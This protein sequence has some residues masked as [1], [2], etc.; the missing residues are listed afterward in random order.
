MIM[1]YS[2]V[3]ICGWHVERARSD[4]LYDAS[5]IQRLE[6]DLKQQSQKHGEEVRSLETR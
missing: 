1:H 6:N 4:K 5:I 2:S 3:P